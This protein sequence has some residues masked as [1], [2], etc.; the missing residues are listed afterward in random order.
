MNVL[1]DK[2]GSTSIDAPASPKPSATSVRAASN[3]KTLSPNL[4]VSSKADEGVSVAE[5]LQANVVLRRDASGQIYYVVT[6]AQTGKE[7]REVPP[8]EVRKVGEGITEYLKQEEAKAQPRL[9]A[10]A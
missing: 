7:L 9:E 3:S 6:D 8:Q 1:L 10:K 2:I 4:R 5:T